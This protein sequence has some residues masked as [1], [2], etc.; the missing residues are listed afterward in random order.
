MPMKS[1]S[2]IITREPAWLGP[3]TDLMLANLLSDF[4]R[5]GFGFR[6]LLKLPSELL[7]CPPQLLDHRPPAVIFE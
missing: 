1:A 6:R 2:K 5:K 4:D 3:A 7:N